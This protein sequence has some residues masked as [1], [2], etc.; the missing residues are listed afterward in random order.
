MAPVLFAVARLQNQ[1]RVR[2]SQEVQGGGLADD[3]LQYQA[4]EHLEAGKTPYHF[5]RRVRVQCE[6]LGNDI[7]GIVE[8]LDPKGLRAVAIP[9][10][11]VHNET[12]VEVEMRT[13]V[14]E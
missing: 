13:Q 2:I 1:I 5:L 9:A 3:L 8:T 7:M 11:K 10:A 6:R 12:V 14:E 4:P